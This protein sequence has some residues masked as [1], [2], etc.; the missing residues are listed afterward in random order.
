MLLFISF[1][2]SCSTTDVKEQGSIEINGTELSRDTFFRRLGSTVSGSLK[3]EMNARVS[4]GWFKWSSLIGVIG[5]KTIPKH[6][7]SSRVATYDAECWPVTKE[8]ESHISVIETKML[9][10]TSGVTHLGCVRNDTYNRGS[11]S[12]SQ[13][14]ARSSASMLRS[15]PSW[16]GP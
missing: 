1:I 9:R 16:H 7:K 15:R 10:R 11:V 3:L 8:H 4:A 14:T 2:S 6:L 5:E 12:D 13:Q